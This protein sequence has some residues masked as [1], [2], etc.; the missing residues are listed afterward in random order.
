MKQINFATLIIVFCL[1][2]TNS[3]QAQSSKKI[4]NKEHA[5]YELIA[6][7]QLRM[8]PPDNYEKSERFNG[9]ENILA[10]SSIMIFK[11]PGSVNE[12]MI[13]FKRNKDIS[14]GM[15]VAKEEL[16]QINGYDALLQSGVQFAHGKA[17]MRYLFVI[18][19]MKNTYVMNASWI[20][21][22][23]YE[24][25]GS[26]IRKALL[27][28]IFDAQENASIADAF[29]YT[30]DNSLCD[31]KAGNILMNSLVFTDDGNIPSNTEAKTVFMVNKSSI[32]KGETAENYLTKVLGSYPIEYSD[33]Q[34]L[35]SNE[36]VVDG[37]SGLEF[38]AIGQNTKLGKSE[39]IYIVLLFD[40]TTVYQLTGTTL[41]FYEEKLECF[42]A[43]ARSFKR[44]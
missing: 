42:K 39:L 25:E 8:V 12:N 37:L 20:K 28:V 13:A 4:I 3:A 2:L 27:G 10:G 5:G 1:L 29:E 6:G 23:D 9:Y 17:Y 30:L 34:E 7:T 11:V 44:K 16:F 40:D 33:N 15:V 18:G 24:K 31:L 35:E 14:Q 41:K 38:Y 32:P 43:M 22:K 26:R 19:D 36:I 21:D